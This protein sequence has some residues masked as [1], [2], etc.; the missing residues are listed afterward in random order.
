MSPPDQPDTI[1]PQYATFDADAY[2]ARINTPAKNSDYFQQFHKPLI[3]EA[4]AKAGGK[5]V[6]LFDVACGHGFELDFMQDDSQVEIVGMDIDVETLR[7]STRKRLS[8]GYFIAGDVGNPP[9]DEGFADVGIA[10]NAVVYKPYDML[11]TLFRALKPGGK[12]AVNFRV[13]GNKFNEPFYQYYL[14]D[15]GQILNQTLTVT[16]GDRTET[17][18][19][20]VLDYRQCSEKKIRNLDRQIYFQSE[21]DIERLIDVVGFSVENHKKFHFQSP[22][23][24]DNEIDVFTLQKPL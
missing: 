4:K 18:A 22:V 8:K 10:V 7:N 16:N 9:I 5:Q 20:K 6:V 15:G 3:D 13:Y 24:P 1:T 21:S 19:L 23:N 2:K 12:C 17:F 14:N 11:K